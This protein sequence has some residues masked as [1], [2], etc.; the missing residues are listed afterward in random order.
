[1]EAKLAIYSRISE[2]FPRASAPK[3]LPLN[4]ATG[5]RVLRY[6]HQH[7]VFMDMGMR[8][9]GGTKFL[10][11]SHV[12]CISSVIQDRNKLGKAKYVTGMD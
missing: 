3:R 7:N 5:E 12:S 4:F 8:S 11:F 9:K 1:M 6:Y 10:P 2:K